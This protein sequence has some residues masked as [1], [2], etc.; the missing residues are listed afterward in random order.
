MRPAL[1][2]SLNVGSEQIPTMNESPQPESRGLEPEGQRTGS[3]AASL[4]VPWITYSV[5]AVCGAIFA[6][7]NLAQ[8]LPSYKQVSDNLMPSSIR[9]WSGAYWGLLTSAFVHLAFWHIL[10]NMWWT[11]DFGLLLEPTMGRVKYFLFIASSA[12]VSS[13][14][15]MACSDQ[16]GIGFSGVV[17]AMFGYALAARRVEPRYGQII[18]Q[19]TIQW[20]LGWL[21][22]CIVL[23]IAKIWNVGNGAHVAGFLFGLCVGNVFAARVWVVASRIALTLL[24]GL[25]VMSVV[26]MPWSQTWKWRVSIA[27]VMA[28]AEQAAKGD[29]KAQY[30][31]GVALNQQDG[32]KPEAVSW[33]TKS[34]TQ[35]YVPAMNMLAWVLATDRDDRLR[36]GAQAVKWAE[37][38]CEKDSRKTAVYLD[39]LAAA[40]AEVDRWEDAVAT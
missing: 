14:A 2:L 31:H 26:Y 3:A 13:G 36:D 25:A 29:A 1:K 12:M 33:L 7:L 30:L 10:F 4:G 27:E 6:Y 5:I 9:I 28:A 18:N 22:L 23:S 24:V 8:E 39:T 16:T 15:Q 19:Q 37:E 17:Y 40:Y 20:L 32:M 11:K 38:A 35:G 21:V 34:A